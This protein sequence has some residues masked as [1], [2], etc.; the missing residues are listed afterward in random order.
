VKFD[1]RINTVRRLTDE[2]S[3][4]FMNNGCFSLECGL[5]NLAVYGQQRVLVSRL[6]E[7]GSY[8]E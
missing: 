2:G 1:F 8:Y 7:E 6:I 4:R 5:V 3:L